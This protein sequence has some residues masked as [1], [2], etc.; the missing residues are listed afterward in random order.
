MLTLFWLIQKEGWI[1]GREKRKR[2][3]NKRVWNGNWERWKE[4]E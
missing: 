2:K 3:E 1:R 4:G